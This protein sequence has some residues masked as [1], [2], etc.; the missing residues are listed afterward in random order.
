MN[1]RNSVARRIGPGLRAV[2]SFGEELLTSCSPDHITSKRRQ[3]DLST[4]SLNRGQVDVAPK[5]WLAVLDRVVRGQ[6]G[7]DGWLTGNR[8]D[9]VDR[10]G[11]MTWMG[12]ALLDRLL[13]QWNTCAA[14]LVIL[15]GSNR[16]DSRTGM[17][18]DKPCR[19]GAVLPDHGP[20]GP[21]TFVD[22]QTQTG[23]V[24]SD[25]SEDLLNARGRLILW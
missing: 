13:K 16:S 10:P 15:W 1:Y 19:V 5:P 12:L 23:R 11:E 2:D 9:A 3:A 20:S 21:T 14:E 4:A 7:K 6:D 17:L 8:L 18:E 25:N 24:R 22:D